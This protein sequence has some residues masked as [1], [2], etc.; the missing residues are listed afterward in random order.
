MTEN[1]QYIFIT[2]IKTEIRNHYLSLLDYFFPNYKKMISNEKTRTHSTQ[3]K[4]D[5]YYKHLLHVYR[6]KNRKI[7]TK[8][9]LLL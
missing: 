3:K 2:F 5:N 7:K 4:L 8:Y 6:Y 1:M 9:T